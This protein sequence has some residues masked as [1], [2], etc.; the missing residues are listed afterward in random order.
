MNK[1]LEKRIIIF[2][3]CDR[4]G[5]STFIEKL[6]NFLV[7]EH[8]KHVFVFHLMGPTKFENLAFDNDDKSLIQLAKFNDEYDFIREILN[9]DKNNHIILDRSSFGEYIW[10]R[11]WK[12]SGK[13]SDYVT[14]NEF[15]KRHLDLFKQTLYIDYYMSDLN[16]LE[17]RIL[18]SEED[19]NI[20]TI[21][22]KSIK[23]NI[24][25]VYDLYEELAKI[26][27]PYIE[28]IKIDSYEF[29]TPEDIEKYF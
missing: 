22:D 19:T 13:Y 11:Y 4:T 12:R 7:N 14:S 28:Y 29:K 6:K 9:E 8:G 20:F 3:G 26:V 27:K 5:K 24:Q 1:F 2:E 21:D 25:Y 10:T 16:I 23:E 17:K 18:D 15:I